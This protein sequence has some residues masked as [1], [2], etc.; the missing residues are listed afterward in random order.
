M[1]TSPATSLKPTAK[2]TMVDPLSLSIAAAAAIVGGAVRG[3]AG[4]AG[5][6]IMLPAMTILFGPVSAVTTVLLVDLVGNLV[7]VPSSA[8]DV[9]WRVAIPLILG[10]VVCMPFGGYLLLVAD[11]SIMK[12]A[13]IYAII[14]I[15]MVMLFGW[16]YQRALGRGAL[17]GV[18]VIS[19]GFLSAAYIGA[20]APIF[21]YAGP[22]PAS[23]SRAN[24]IM[25]AFVSSAILC[26]GFVVG[27][28]I[29]ETELLR[30]AILAPFYLAAIFAGSRLYLGID[31]T[32]FRRTV[33]LIL[34]GGSIVGIAFF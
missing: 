32:L 33:L 15:S 24:T 21:L 11:P 5:P 9:S 22:E 25:W 13:I 6:M 18:G 3:Y 26:V 34:I 12:Q 16:R 20:I 29:T 7:L 31:E 17:F 2:N 28:V 23:N 27:G 8:R 14:A 1:G 30:A 19:G 10:S 4:F